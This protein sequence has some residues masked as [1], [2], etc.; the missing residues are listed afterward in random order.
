MFKSDLLIRDVTELEKTL[1]VRRLDRA[2]RSFISKAVLPPVQHHELW[3][4]VHPKMAGQL[5]AGG[6]QQDRRVSAGSLN[7]ED[8][9]SVHRAMEFLHHHPR[10]FI[11]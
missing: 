3:D 11:N 5:G 2:S 1:D 6:V 7:L 10:E 4:M 8:S 9:S